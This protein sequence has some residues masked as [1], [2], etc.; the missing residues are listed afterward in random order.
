MVREGRGSGLDPPEGNSGGR[1]EEAGD[2]RRGSKSGGAEG[3][4]LCPAG[5]TLRAARAPG[6]EGWLCDGC[7]EGLVPGCEIHGEG[8]PSKKVWVCA[9]PM[10]LAS[11]RLSRTHKRFV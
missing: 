10:L 8:V 9:R 11:L 2:K 4:G 6:D 3:W 5:H 7:G 1:E